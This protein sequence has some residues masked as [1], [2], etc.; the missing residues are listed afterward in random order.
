MTSRISDVEHL[1]ATAMGM[2]LEF[3]TMSSIENAEEVYVA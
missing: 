2:P 1:F 3:G